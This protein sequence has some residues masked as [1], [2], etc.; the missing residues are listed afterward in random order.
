MNRSHETFER[1][2]KMKTLRQGDVLLIRVRRCPSTATQ[3]EDG[4]ILARGE[5]TGHAHRIGEGAEIFVD[6]N[7]HGRRYL[8][9]FKDTYLDHEEHTRVALSIGDYEIVRQREY[10]P[11]AVRVVS[12]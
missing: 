4:C 12:D 8:R 2:K 7:D 5:T 9:V 1:S 3:K 11:Q 6:V 10:T